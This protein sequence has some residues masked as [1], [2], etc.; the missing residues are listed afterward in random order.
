MHMTFRESVDEYV[1]EKDIK[2]INKLVVLRKSTDSQKYTMSVQATNTNLPL[3][4][5]GILFLFLE[6]S[7]K[8]IE[9]CYVYWS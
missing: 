7:A 8:P 9:I 5:P 6:L 3:I 1:H 2:N 4:E